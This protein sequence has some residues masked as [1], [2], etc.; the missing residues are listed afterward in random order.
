MG[1]ECEV[2]ENGRKALEKAR[3]GGFDMILMDIQMPE[4][5]GIEAAGR[6]VA[7]VPPEKR[8]WI[9]AL[10]AGATRDN[11]EEAL[12]AGMDG[13]LTKPVQPNDLETEL[14][15]AAEHARGR[16]SLVE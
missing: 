14:E 16:A 11:R 15:R 12:G 13:Y 5:D 3:S 9:V 1:Y 2:V 4:M 7:E 6:I 8:P 10:T